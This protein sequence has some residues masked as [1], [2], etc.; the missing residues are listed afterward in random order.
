MS[1]RSGASEING[2]G[3]PRDARPRRRA[4]VARAA[5]AFL[6]L[7]GVLTACDPDR[8]TGPAG[9]DVAGAAP[10][11][12]DREPAP[13]LLEVTEPVGAGNDGT[14]NA[15]PFEGTEQNTCN[16]DVVPV[17]GTVSYAFFVSDGDVTH[18]RVQFHWVV[19]GESIGTDHVYHGSSQYIEDLNV[20]L[21]P[22]SQTFVHNVT[23][24]SPDRTVPDLRMKFLFHLTISGTGTPTATVEK[25]PTEECR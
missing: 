9:L 20:S 15:I 19:D 1:S 11:I 13:T 23:L 2:T 4:R 21:L 16:G 7:A 6:L 8:L 12:G 5:G 25:G 22:M 3:G 17:R 24:Q 14:E 18:Q 10:P